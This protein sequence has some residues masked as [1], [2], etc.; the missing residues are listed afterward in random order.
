MTDPFTYTLDVDV[1]IGEQLHSL[2]FAGG[3]LQRA[4][5]P[6]MDIILEPS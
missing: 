1:K 3:S 6:G 4:S 5:A 2:S